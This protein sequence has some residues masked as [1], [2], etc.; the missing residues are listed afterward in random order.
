MTDEQ[1]SPDQWVCPT[2]VPQVTR[3]LKYHALVVNSKA[4]PDTKG[5]QSF[6]GNLEAQ[7]QWAR[8]ALKQNDAA[9]EVVVYEIIERPVARVRRSLLKEDSPTVERFT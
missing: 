7:I 2:D 1:Q 3:P 4:G 6:G 9:D 5:D 8:G